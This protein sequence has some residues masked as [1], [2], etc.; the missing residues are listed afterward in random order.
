[1]QI[2]VQEQKKNI[3]YSKDQSNINTQNTQHHAQTNYKF[4]LSEQEMKKERKKNQI[5][6]NQIN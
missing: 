5:K 1:M 4:K 2:E 3:K 6:S